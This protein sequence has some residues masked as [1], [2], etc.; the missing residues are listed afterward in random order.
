VFSAAA[1]GAR[2]RGGAAAGALAAVGADSLLAPAATMLSDAQ[3]ALR[4]AAADALGALALAIGLP[5]VSCVSPRS[6]VVRFSTPLPQPDAW[7]RGR[8]CLTRYAVFFEFIT[9]NPLYN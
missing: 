8:C 6:S 1:V 5:R 2:A 3:P 4:L 7:C 9:P